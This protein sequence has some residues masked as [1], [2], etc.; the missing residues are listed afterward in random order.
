MAST[1]LFSLVRP[2]RLAYF[3]A[4]A[5]IEGKNWT[6]EV[7]TWRDETLPG[8][9]NKF[10]PNKE[11]LDFYSKFAQNR[12]KLG[13]SIWSEDEKVAAAFKGKNLRVLGD[14]KGANVA[15][16]P[17]KSGDTLYALM[18]DYFR[19]VV[20]EK[21]AAK[22]RNE[23]VSTLPYMMS[24]GL[25]VDHLEKGGKIAIT[26]GLLTLTDA[27]GVVYAKNVRI[28][29][30]EEGETD[31]GTGHSGETDAGTG[32]SGET[33]AGTGHSGE[34]DAG[35]G[36]SGETDAGT[37]HSGETDAGTGHSGE[38]DA[39]TGHSGETDAGTG[40]TEDADAGTG[41]EGEADA[42][43]G[44]TEDA[45]AGTGKDGEADAGTGKTEDA[46]AGTGKDGEADAGTGKTEDADAGTGKEGEAD[47]GT[48]KDGEADAGTGKTEDADAGT[49]KEGEADAGTGKTEDADAGTGKEGEA[50][51]G[52][53][54]TE[55]ADA[56]TGKEGEADA[57]TGKTE[58][59]DA[60]TGKEGEADAGTG[61]T[62]DADAGTG[63]TEDADAGTGKTEDADAGTGKTEDADALLQAET[64]EE[65]KQNWVNDQ[66]KVAIWKTPNLKDH[67]LDLVNGKGPFY[68][69][70][71]GVLR[72]SETLPLTQIWNEKRVTDTQI[73]AL[74]P[75]MGKAD[76]SLLKQLN[77]TW[78][79]EWGEKMKR[80][81]EGIIAPDMST[82]NFILLLPDLV[83]VN[84]EKM[85]DSGLIILDPKDPKQ[86]TWIPF[87]PKYEFVNGGSPKNYRI[88][89]KKDVEKVES[90]KTL[91]ELSPEEKAGL[92][93]VLPTTATKP[94]MIALQQKLKVQLLTQVEFD[95]N[96]NN[97]IYEPAPGFVWADDNE[98]SDNVAVKFEVE[99]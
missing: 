5:P 46:D 29:P 50:D 32:H 15:E 95:Y 3:A 34:T 44:K 17:I 90:L 20:G 58:D 25:N 74:P 67:P 23:V 62:E 22:L 84:F 75:G 92:K 37:G 72:F 91:A 45:D 39:G 47:A 31:A 85:R 55:D 38:T 21:D 81:E 27:K 54:K 19:N 6:K 2:N 28:K 26:D 53:G 65:I 97:A 33:D 52:T 14:L 51:A 48:G 73:T 8:K 7:K 16:K 68:I 66:V 43:T 57:G 63:K 35:T 70:N 41:K 78:D 9:L 98:N 69:D 80:D 11:R 13:I 12:L 61:K 10:T 77:T 4:P 83:E 82:L 40:K 49:G 94:E 87:D 88:R 64:P 59:A 96:N 79:K 99:K 76:D 36:H 56:G 1:L 71:D 93:N 30:G 89:L 18:E 24:Q 86:E 42:G 60:G